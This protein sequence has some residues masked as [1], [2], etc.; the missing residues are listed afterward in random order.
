M[1]SNPLAVFYFIFLQQVPACSVVA[2]TVGLGCRFYM[3]DL[4]WV[5]FDFSILD[6]MITTM[7]SFSWFDYC[8]DVTV[9]N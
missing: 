9:Q 1:R 8:I 5:S 2:E 4:F 7:C 6:F 3:A